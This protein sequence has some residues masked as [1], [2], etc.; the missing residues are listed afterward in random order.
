MIELY[1]LISY[2]VGNFM[3]ACFVGKVY[4]VNL[5]EERSKNLGTR[6]AGSVIGKGAFCCSITSLSKKIW[7]VKASGG[8]HGI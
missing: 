1:W 5:Q 6:N 2:F 3:R 8:C 7:T 4:G